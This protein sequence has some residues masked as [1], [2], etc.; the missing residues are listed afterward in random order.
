V[1]LRDTN[2]PLSVD[3]F[4]EEFAGC[5]C[6]S[7]IDL[8]SGYDQLTL[9]ATSPGLLRVTTPRQGATNSVAQFVRVVVTMMPFL[10]GIGVKGPYTDYCGEEISPGVRRF[11]FEHTE[12]LDKILDRI[13]RTGASIGT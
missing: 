12:N 4:F 6:A 8:L 7:L 5:N 13:E 11:V 9:D 2:L 1:T 3:E 10:D